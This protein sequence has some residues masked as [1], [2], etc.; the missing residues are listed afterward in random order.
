MKASIILH[1]SNLHKAPM[2]CGITSNVP[3]SKAKWIR[4]TNGQG[5]WIIQ[6]ELHIIRK[7]WICFPHDFQKREQTRSLS[8]SKSTFTCSHTQATYFEWIPCILGADIK[9]VIL[10]VLRVSYIW[11]SFAFRRSLF[12]HT[13][14]QILLW[15]TR[16]LSHISLSIYHVCVIYSETRST[17]HVRLHMCTCACMLQI[18]ARM[19]PSC[20]A[21]AAHVGTSV[22]QLA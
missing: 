10:N 7:G 9:R 5:G 2:I 6:K 13:S 16:C 19:L 20:H 4:S 12:S 8:T 1:S 18:T 22:G 21:I 14:A 15:P 11:R 17:T 3:T